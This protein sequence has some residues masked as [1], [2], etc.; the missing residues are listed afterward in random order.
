MSA[1]CYLLTWCQ[2]WEG[3]MDVKAGRKRIHMHYDDHAVGLA[4]KQQQENNTGGGRVTL[5]STL[6]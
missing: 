3:A 1:I 6:R 4:S 2:E 5:L